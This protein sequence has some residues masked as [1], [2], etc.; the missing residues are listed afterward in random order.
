MYRFQHIHSSP[1]PTLTAVTMNHWF[2][3]EEEPPS[4]HPVQWVRLVVCRFLMKGSRKV[5]LSCYN[6]RH[7]LPPVD[8]VSLSY[9]IDC[10]G[11]YCVG[12]CGGVKA[13]AL[14]GEKFRKART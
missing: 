5:E 11:G 13:D 3:V 8:I 14:I 2:A 4:Y 1:T 9:I 6:Q 12:L 7:T 10:V